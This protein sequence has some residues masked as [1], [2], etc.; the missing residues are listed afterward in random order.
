MEMLDLDR[1]ENAFCWI[2]RALAQSRRAARLT[3]CAAVR[4]HRGAA[5]R[6]RAMP[7][8]TTP[9]I[10]VHR[11]LTTVSDFLVLRACSTLRHWRV[12]M[13]RKLAVFILRTRTR[14]AIVG[15]D[16]VPGPHRRDR[17]RCAGQ[18]RAGRA[19]RN[20]RADTD[21]ANHRRLGRSAL[22][23]SLAG[24]LRDHRGA[25]RIQHLSQRTR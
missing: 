25:Q 3:L 20:Q 2:A 11:Q 7:L 16:A 10:H 1:A 18:R 5:D 22:S 19:R 9:R 4:H 17:A 14:R 15:A 12:G 24:R 23:Q 6:F 21:V 8:V 13:R